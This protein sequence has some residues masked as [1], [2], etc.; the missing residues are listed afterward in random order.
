MKLFYIIYSL[1][2]IKLTEIRAM[3]KELQEANQRD[4]IRTAIQSA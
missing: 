2:R 3:M 4:I 1:D